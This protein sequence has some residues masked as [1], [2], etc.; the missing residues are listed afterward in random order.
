MGL[1]GLG[2]NPFFA[3]QLRPED[4]GLV[5]LRIT[6]VHRTG[7]VLS[8]GERECEIHLG[9]FWFRRPAEER[10][11]VGDWVLT[12]TARTRVERCLSRFSVLQRVAAG[13]QGEVQ[14]I[15]ANVDKLFVV[16]SCNA[17]F[18]AS[19]LKRYLALAASED[20]DPLI[21]LTK[22]DL[23]ADPLAYRGQA[24]EAAPGLPVEVVNA[25]DGATLDGVRDWLRPGRTIALLG[26][27]G[28]G[29]STLLNTLAG[30]E[31]Q[32]TRPIREQ[33]AKGR[34]TTT[35]RSLN[36]LPDGT[37]VL[38]GPGVRE[39]GVVIGER[40]L[41]EFY[42]DVEALA[43]RCRYSNCR[44]QTEPDCAVRA[45]IEAGRLDPQRVRDY[46]ALAAEGQRQQTHAADRR[47]RAG[48]L[49]RTRRSGLRC[50]GDD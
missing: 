38:D 12:D 44:H 6:A 26:S 41:D 43:A 1:T 10:P 9:R 42:D 50:D 7:H 4:D 23:A 45:E 47:R 35:H 33:D 21:V 25:L 16:T 30:D 14:L 3:A 18:S 31:L 15:G 39:L 2:W 34:H 27:S 37:L 49:E 5:P 24:A 48:R 17:E 22:A 11:T 8:D 29:K 19:R 13:S 40:D 32:V 28:V 46:Q 20:I 36:P